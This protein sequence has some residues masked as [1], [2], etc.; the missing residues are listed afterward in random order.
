MIN[1][2]FEKIKKI[3]QHGHKVR[4]EFY[5]V[6]SLNFIYV[7]ENESLM[8]DISTLWTKSEIDSE[9]ITKITP[10]PRPIKFLKAGDRVDILENAKDLPDYEN[11]YDSKKAMVGETKLEIND[12]GS[13]YYKIGDSNNSHYFPFHCVSPH[14]EEEEKTI[15]IEGKDYTISEI[16]KALNKGE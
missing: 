15:N 12:I 7:T 4:V 6:T 14:I 9:S 8:S 1:N 10:I 16:K 11:W 2:A 5:D 13:C 3:L